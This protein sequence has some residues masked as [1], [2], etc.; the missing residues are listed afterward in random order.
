V[1]YVAVTIAPM[2]SRESEQCDSKHHLQWAW[3]DAMSKAENKIEK[4]TKHS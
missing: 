3:Q 2:G 4:K 1:R